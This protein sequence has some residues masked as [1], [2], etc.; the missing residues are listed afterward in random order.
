MFVVVFGAAAAF[1]GSSAESTVPAAGVGCVDAWGEARYTNYGYDHIVHLR[2]RCRVRVL[3]EVSTNVNPRAIRV[4]LPAGESLEV[5]TFRGS[6]T[7]EFTPNAR[8]ELPGRSSKTAVALGPR[9][10][11]AR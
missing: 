3:C 1:A 10:S 11:V 7:R 6:P 4:S 8:C 2:S 9:R 5:L